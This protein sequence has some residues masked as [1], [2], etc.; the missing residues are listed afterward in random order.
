MQNPKDRRKIL[1]DERLRG[2]FRVRSIDM[3]KMNKALS[4]HIW[5]MD[6]A[7]GIVH[8]QAMPKHQ[9][10]FAELEMFIYK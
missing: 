3:F 4:K 7:Q 8:R 10:C 5:P 9:A 6:E 2:I 1:C